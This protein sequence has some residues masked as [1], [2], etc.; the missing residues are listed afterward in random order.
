MLISI[1]R[2]VISRQRNARDRL[3]FQWRRQDLWQGGAIGIAGN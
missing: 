1:G 2:H 3:C